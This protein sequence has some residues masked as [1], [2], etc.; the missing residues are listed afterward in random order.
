MIRAVC[1][2]LMMFF[3]FIIGALILEAVTFYILDFV[4][5]PTYFWYNFVLILFLALLVYAIPNYTAQYVIYTIILFVQTV[6]AYIN[7][8]LLN[9]F[10]DMFSFDMI[11][12]AGEAGAAIATSFVYFAIILQLLSIFAIIAIFGGILLKKCRADKFRCRICRFGRYCLFTGKRTNPAVG[13]FPRQ[14]SSAAIS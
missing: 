1:N 7:Y 3:Y 10:G 9:I 12:L 14:P 5:L 11:N 8:S 13:A 6:F 2:K 4:N